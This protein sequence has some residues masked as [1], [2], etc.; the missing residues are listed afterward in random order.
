M[1]VNQAIASLRRHFLSDQTP[2]TGTAKINVGTTERL[3]STAGGALLTY[4]GIKRGTSPGGVTMATLGGA[5]LFRGATG[6]CSVNEALG[7]D[8][9]DHELKPIEITQT[10]TLFKYR[11]DVY[12]FWRHLENL[13][14][15]MHHLQKVTQLDSKRSH[16]EA[17]IPGGL[18]TIAWEAE[19]VDDRP[20]ELISWRS[21]PG[22]QIDNSGE[23]TFIEAPGGKGTE[24]QATICYRAPIGA[25]GKSVATL[26]N[27]ALAQMVREDLR[28]FKQLMESGE[29]PTIE[30][31]PSGRA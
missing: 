1:A 2:A 6:Y 10:F 5:L 31:Q 22:S 25:L 11:H 28:R 29:I 21:L 4:Y 23:V 15:F 8:T 26:L 7:R 27:P 16:W 12:N 9:S 18:G 24:V 13:P 3:L 17:K 20:D 30:G 14:R 19:I